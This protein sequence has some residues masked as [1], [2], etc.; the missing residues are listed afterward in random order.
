MKAA[1]K[2]EAGVKADCELENSCSYY[3]LFPRH[4]TRALAVVFESYLGGR[5]KQG[6]FSCDAPFSGRQLAW[7]Q[8]SHSQ[9]TGMG[10][11]VSPFLSHLVGKGAPSSAPLHL[12]PSTTWYDQPR[13]GYEQDIAVIMSSVKSP[14]ILLQ[15]SHCGQE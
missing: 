2:K 6:S 15:G 3:F 10:T 13:V 8:G 4:Y 9:V 11:S 1:H 7:W 12:D 5:E 14:G